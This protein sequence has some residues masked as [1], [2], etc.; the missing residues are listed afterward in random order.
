MY[1]GAT[2]LSNWYYDITPKSGTGYEAKADE[3][4]N[5]KFIITFNND[6]D[7]TD[8]VVFTITAK[9]NS[10]ST[11]TWTKNY[12]VTKNRSGIV[13]TAAVVYEIVPSVTS[14]NIDN[15]SAA[16]ETFTFQI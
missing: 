4:Q 6:F 14:I 16:T 7:N 9:E 1:D 8:S 3:N 15:T 13:G 10:T 12:R 2:Q 11:T 5:N